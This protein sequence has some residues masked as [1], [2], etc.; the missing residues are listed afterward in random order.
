MVYIGQ[1][2][3]ENPNDR[4]K[5]H[6]SKARKLVKWLQKPEGERP[7]FK[8]YKSCLYNAMAEHGIENFTFT[9]IVQTS[10]ELLDEWEIKLISEFDCLKP[11]GYNM[12]TGGGH[13]KHH[14]DT[15]KLMSDV[16]KKNAPKLIDKYRRE[17]TKGLP[18][19]IIYHNKGNR[20]GFAINEH[21]LC[22]YKSFTIGDDYKT[23]EDCKNAAV[24]FLEE[25]NKN[26]E[27]YKHQIKNDVSLP[28]GITRFRRGFL[29]K[30][31]IKGVI[32]KKTFEGSDLDD[33]KL[34]RAKD[35]LNEI[36]KNA[37]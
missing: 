9:P 17:E 31:K 37:D 4:W 10:D 27:T 7:R 3:Y 35:Y 24:K 36:N 13:H 30:R 14:E 16:A 5:G 34:Q 12:T 15:K 28:T 6:Q 18:M 8:D 23:E 32:Y 33:I 22:K 1:T 11:K 25:L 2:S 29:V 20:K 21:P 19:Y 26:G